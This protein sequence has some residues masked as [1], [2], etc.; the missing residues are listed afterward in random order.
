MSPVP[1]AEHPQAGEVASCRPL[2]C[3]GS[4]CPTCMLCGARDCEAGR[5]LA[6]CCALWVHLL[7]AFKLSPQSMH[8]MIFTTGGAA[9]TSSLARPVARPAAPVHLPGTRASGSQPHSDCRRCPGHYVKRFL[10]LV[11][12]M[13]QMTGL[14]GGVIF[15]AVASRFQRHLMKLIATATYVIWW[16]NPSFR[17]Y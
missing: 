4:Q 14:F 6:F 2:R 12:L 16:L 15:G 7:K 11:A 10:P 5:H 1:H 9:N 8:V 13:K 3:Q 17:F